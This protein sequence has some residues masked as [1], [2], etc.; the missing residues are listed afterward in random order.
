VESRDQAGNGTFIVSKV[1]F[2]LIKTRRAALSLRAGRLES[3][4]ES[5]VDFRQQDEQGRNNRA[6]YLELGIGGE[7]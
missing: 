2:P 7:Q 6:F 3:L 5:A 1:R 4:C